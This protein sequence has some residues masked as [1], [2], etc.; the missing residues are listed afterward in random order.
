MS[1]NP[2]YDAGEYRPRVGLDSL[3]IAEIIADEEGT[4]T[5]DTP[6]YLA[7]AAEASQA[8]TIKTET[9][10]ADDQA[11]DTFTTKGET[12]INLSVTNIPLGLLAKLT[13]QSYDEASG[14]FYEY[15]GVAPYFA[16]MF[17]SLKSNGNYRYYCFPKCKFDVPDEA[18]STKG[19]TPDVK[20]LALMVH[21][22]KTTCKFVID[23]DTNDGLTRIIGDEDVTAFDPTGW[24]TAVPVP[25]VFVESV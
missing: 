12:A 8:S 24:F 23:V 21:A 25:E 17:R 9:I 13:G 3:Y 5:A 2:G 7:P 20:M 11:Y 18:A 4:F 22:I 19:E 6:E 15:G 10:Y 1:E 16:L 14:L